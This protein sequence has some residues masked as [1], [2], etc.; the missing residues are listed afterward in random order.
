MLRT[1][2]GRN[3]VPRSSRIGPGL[4]YVLRS[5]PK[6]IRPNRNSGTKAGDLTER[7]H[8]RHAVVSECPAFLSVCG[9][10]YDHRRS[11]PTTAQLF[12][13]RRR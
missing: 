6:P 11:M 4:A 12:A 7:S 9:K 3:I 10:L 13:A 2:Q 8:H 1:K 5:G